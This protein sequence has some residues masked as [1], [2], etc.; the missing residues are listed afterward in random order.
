MKF[1]KFIYRFEIKKKDAVALYHSLLVK[2]VFLTHAELQQVEVALRE[3]AFP[4]KNIEETLLFLHRNYFLVGS[5]EE[6]NDLFNKCLELIYPQSISNAYLVVT[7][8]CNFK[9]KYCFISETVEANKKNKMMT[10]EVAKATAELLQRT[11]ERQ[12]TDYDKTITFYGGEPLMN[13]EIIKFF[14]EE[15]KRIKAEKYFPDDVRCALITNGSLLNEEIIG[16]LRENNIAI[17]I[18]YDID[19]VAH[20]NRVNK[21]DDQTFDVVREKIE[22]CKQKEFPFSLSI[23]ITENTIN[24]KEQILEEILRLGPKTVAFNL[25]IPNHREVP[26]NSYYEK[27]TDF[28]IDMFKELRK[29]GIYEDRIMRKVQAFK[30]NKLYLYDC[31]AAGGNQYVISPSGEIGICHGYLNNRKYFSG[32]VFDKS[33]E[34]HENKDFQYWRNRSPLYMEKCF[35][36]ECLGICGGGCPYAAEYMHGSI[37]DLD[38]RFCI[39]AKK[40]LHWLIDDLYENIEKF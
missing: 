25:L 18:S 37:Y 29:C 36:C 27:A 4:N 40:V 13:F 15:L 1:S 38:D 26:S 22:L 34:F 39:H 2:T 11:Y 16:F 12:Q 17:S 32:N 8:N 9:C 31:C 23:T 20:A 10:G 35:S 19:K 7:E 28:M 24:S 30:D 33:F 6:D 21:N 5:D 14:I 3:K